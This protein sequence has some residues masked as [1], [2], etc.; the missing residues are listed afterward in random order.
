MAS[1]TKPTSDASLTK[2]RRSLALLVAMSA[3]ACSKPKVTA[4][5]TSHEPTNTTG[6]N[7]TT[8]SK[9]RSPESVQP[10][11]ST[12]AYSIIEENKQPGRKA[13]F[14]V[15][16][17]TA[18]EQAK[19]RELALSIR[20]SRA[21]DNNPVFIMFY[22]PGMQV[23]AGAYAAARF[24]PDLTVEVLGVTPAERNRLKRTAAKE[25]LIG[26]W[27]DQTPLTGGVITI[28]KS[29]MLEQKFKDNSM[30]KIKLSETQVSRGRRFDHVP[31]SAF[32]DHYVL[33]PSGNLEIRDQDGMISTA[34]RMH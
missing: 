26:R 19:V 18:I 32:G 14:N 31:A 12:S 25:E 13:S 3:F 30:R 15:R 22:L 1:H 4:P 16:I 5:V 28:S 7:Q 29:L 2:M 6:S 11:S 10:R 24:T 27:L 34:K 23:G 9:P 33:L 20:R 17:P 21:T 8:P